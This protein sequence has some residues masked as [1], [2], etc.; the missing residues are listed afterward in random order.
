MLT[1]ASWLV[2]RRSEILPIVILPLSLVILLL[3]FSLF[4]SLLPRPLELIS[5][6][7]KM[8]LIVVKLIS[9]LLLRILLRLLLILPIKRV[10][11]LLLIC[12]S[13]PVEIIPLAVFILL[14]L[15]EWSLLNLYLFVFFNQLVLFIT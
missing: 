14:S 15:I 11:E 10:L 3:R 8:P 4:L 1:L 5:E 7:I 9:S 2:S 6:T 12:L 13:C